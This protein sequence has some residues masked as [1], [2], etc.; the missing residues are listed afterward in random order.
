MAQRDEGNDREREY[1]GAREQ[2]EILAAQDEDKRTDR[3][4]QHAAKNAHAIIDAGI[5]SRH[6]GFAA[7][8]DEKEVMSDPVERIKERLQ[9]RQTKQ[10]GP[11][12]ERQ[13]VEGRDEYHAADNANHVTARAPHASTTL[14]ARKFRGTS[15]P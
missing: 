10:D 14:R 9:D 5:S 4:S 1:H 2:Q 3:G 7:R 11:A 8:L 15:M 13:I 12:A 6:L